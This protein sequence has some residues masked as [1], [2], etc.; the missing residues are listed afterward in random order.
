[1]DCFS[2][3]AA[4]SW[5]SLTEWVF[6]QAPIY[7]LF[8]ILLGALASLYY[9]KRQ[10]ARALRSQ[11]DPVLWPAPGEAS[12]KRAGV[13]MRTIHLLRK[14]NP[15][16]GGTETAI[17]GLFE[18]LHQRGVTTVAYCPRLG[19]GPEM[20]PLRAAGCEVRRFRA[21]LPVAGISRERRRQMVAVGGNLMSF[22]LIRSLWRERDALAYSTRIP[23]AGSGGVARTIPRDAAGCP[24]SFLFMAGPLDLPEPVRQDFVAARRRMG[25]GQVLRLA[26][27]LA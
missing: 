9:L 26:V 7:F 3:S 22:D 15:A 17:Q 25:M 24:S 14:F 16:D 21:F 20:E 1:M 5:Q 27:S 19:S 11:I 2:G 12:C 6:R 10:E 23:W 8:H 18:G 13:T 4:S